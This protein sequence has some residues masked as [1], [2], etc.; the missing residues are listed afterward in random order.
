MRFVIWLWRVMTDR[1]TYTEIPDWMYPVS[2]EVKGAC[3]LEIILVLGSVAAAVWW[4]A[5]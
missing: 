3:W 4:F 1:P 5:G 2:I